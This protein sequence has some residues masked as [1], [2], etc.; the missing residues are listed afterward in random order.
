M[1]R[2]YVTVVPPWTRHWYT[3]ATREGAD[4]RMGV[5]LRWWPAST[6]GHAVGEIHSNQKPPPL[7]PADLR[8]APGNE[9]SFIG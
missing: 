4:G 6:V 2:R 1:Q 5:P 7:V 3:T 9:P 8:K